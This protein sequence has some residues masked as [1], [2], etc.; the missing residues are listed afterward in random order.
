MPKVK[1][2]D[3][4]DV[5]LTSEEV[6]E[7][8]RTTV[9]ALYQRQHRGTGPPAI[10]SGSKLLYNLAALRKWEDSA[11]ALPGVIA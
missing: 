9:P 10:K 11:E 3:P 7:R 2:K 5:W 4:R 1:A 8:L 6:A